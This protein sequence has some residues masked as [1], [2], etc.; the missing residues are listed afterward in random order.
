MRI[1]KRADW[2]EAQGPETKDSF[3]FKDESVQRWEI[4]WE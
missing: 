1:K 4:F 2:V 3:W